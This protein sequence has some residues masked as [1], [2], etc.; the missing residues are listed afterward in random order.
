MSDQQ[1]DPKIKQ[2]SEQVESEK[3]EKEQIRAEFDE[4]S[5]K[6]QEEAVNKFED[7]AKGFDEKWEERSKLHDEEVSRLKEE[8]KK[9]AASKG[10]KI[11]INPKGCY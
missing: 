10:V 2:L 4:K 5:K 1:E 8:L 7:Q 9:I 11:N 6:Q 3:K